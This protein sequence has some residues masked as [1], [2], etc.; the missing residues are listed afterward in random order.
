MKTIKPEQPAESG[1]QY[2]DLAGRIDVTF[3][4]F[5]QVIPTDEPMHRDATPGEGSLPYSGNQYATP[6]QDMAP[7]APGDGPQRDFA[8]GYGI[9]VDAAKGYNQVSEISVD[10]RNACRG[11]K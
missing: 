5:M 6:L 2:D 11:A 10:A 1:G 4:R 3:N 8:D 9:S 7:D